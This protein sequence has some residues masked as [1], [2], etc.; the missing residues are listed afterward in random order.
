MA[1]DGWEMVGCEYDD[2][3]ENYPVRVYIDFD[4]EGHAQRFASLLYESEVFSNEI[5]RLAKESE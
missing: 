5:K 2:C 4:D 1:Y 3:A